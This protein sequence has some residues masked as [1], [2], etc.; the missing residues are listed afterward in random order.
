[1]K[2]IFILISVLF[3]FSSITAQN[4]SKYDNTNFNNNIKFLEAIGESTENL[5]LNK[6]DVKEFNYKFSQITYEEKESLFY[7]TNLLA[8]KKNSIY[9]T[10]Y[11]FINLAIKLNNTNKENYIEWLSYF[12][13]ILLNKKNKRKHIEIYLKKSM[14]LIYKGILNEKS[15]YRWHISPIKFN[16]KYIN[17]NLI[18]S[19]E[20]CSLFAATTTDTIQIDSTCGI[21][22]YNR[23]K[24]TGKLGKITWGDNNYYVLS[25]FFRMMIFK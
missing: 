8:K 10:F 12:E 16:L 21:Y 11:N 4:N 24:W 5:N 1:M 7:F 13:S 23:K 19:I 22:N 20:S 18:L 25:K 14:D 17:K 6:E 2:E 15:G 3:V 9:P